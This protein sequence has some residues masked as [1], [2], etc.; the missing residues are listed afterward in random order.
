MNR[1]PEQSAICAAVASGQNVMVE[2]LAGCAKST[3]II[4]A[5][6]E[7]PIKRLES[8]LILA[9]N[10][11]IKLEMEKKITEAELPSKVKVMTLNGL[12]HLAIM[13]S[14][15]SLILDDS[16]IFALVKEVGLRGDDFSDLFQLV[17]SARM[18]GI[19]PRGLV[20]K[21]LLQDTDENW[22][23][24]C[25]RLD[26]DPILTAPARDILA[27]S[28]RLA[29]AGTIDFDD[30]LYISTLIVGRYP[31]FNTVFVDEAQDLSPFNHLQVQRAARE[32]IV[33]VGDSHQAIYAWRGADV[34]SMLNLRRLRPQWTDLTLSTTF[35]CPVEVVKRQNS[36]V[37]LFTAAEGNPSGSISFMKEWSPEGGATSAILCRNNAPLIRLAFQLLR[38]RIPV[39]MLGK[40]IGRDLKRLYNKLSQKGKLSMDQ[41]MASCEQ[42]IQKDP[43]KSDRAESLLAVLESSSSLD[44]ALKFL[45][46]ARTNSLALATGHR[47]K[48]MEWNTVYH[49]NPYL[50]PSNH[51]TEMPPGEAKDKALQQERNLRYVIETR[52][53]DALRFVRLENLEL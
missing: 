22:A 33:A 6:R 42:M 27:K 2:A 49:L 11:K 50:I 40:D 28:I 26:I 39:N 13:K 7:L 9:F 29:L 14:G 12:G 30:Q 16:K 45:T 35:R 5:L 51:V 32:Q 43:D 10:K 36:F 52:T 4:E 20:G 44:D 48:G 34:D 15:R 38:E 41:V 3:S 25:D 47:A 37:P 24:L 8:T 19:I 1:T 31:T 17:K 23:G 21:P 18:A 46:E 53:R